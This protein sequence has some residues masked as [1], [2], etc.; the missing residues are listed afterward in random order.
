MAGIH[1]KLA[2]KRQSG[3]AELTEEIMRDIGA[4]V[5]VVNVIKPVHNFK[6]AE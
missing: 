3:R 6:A 1:Q 5:S 2:V 4:T